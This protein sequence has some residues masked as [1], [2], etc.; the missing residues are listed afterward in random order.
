MNYLVF[1]T[2]SKQFFNALKLNLTIK[3]NTPIFVTR[4]FSKQ[5]F[6]FRVIIQT[7]DNQID[8]NYEMSKIKR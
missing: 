4:P 7:V 8:L 2:M 6:L 1:E 5:L 3:I